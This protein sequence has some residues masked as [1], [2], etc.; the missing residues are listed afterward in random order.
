MLKTLIKKQLLENVA[1]IIRNPKNGKKRGKGA[2]IGFAI[3]YIYL[4]A[5]FG[6]LTF[7]IGD[8]LWE[9]YSALNLEWLYFSVF[10]I[11]ATT[12]GVFMGIFTVYTNLYQAKDNELLLSLP[13]PPS[14]MLIAKMF[15]CYLMTFIFEA[16]VL[17]PCYI[18]YFINS[19]FSVQNFIISVANIL[20]MP[21]FAVAIGCILGWVVALISSKIKK[22]IRTIV[23]VIVSIVFFGAY[24]YIISDA[25]AFMKNFIAHTEK[26]ADVAKS[27]F[28]LFYLFGKGCLGDLKALMIFILI[29]AALIFA[30]IFVLS[31]TFIKIV[32]KEKGSSVKKFKKQSLSSASTGKAL[33]KRE[34]ARYTSSAVYILNCTM[35]VILTV[36]AI[37][38]TILK[39]DILL[40][41]PAEY[42]GIIACGVIAMLA[43]M[44]DITAPSVSLE[45]RTLWIV[46][47]LPV[48]P[49]EILKAKLRM[50]VILSAVP[51][52]IFVGV[53]EVIFDMTLIARIMLPVYA[54][55]FSLCEAAF[56]LMLNIKMP[57]LTWKN[58]TV[59]VK[60]SMNVLAALL[61][62]MGIIILLAVPYFI[63]NDILKADLYIVL[64]AA[65]VLAVTIALLVWIKKKGTEIFSKL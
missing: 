30:V 3:L 41:I 15:N 49:W 61:G 60:Q 36:L 65:V 14:K 5:L 18:V 56:G 21:L 28:Y 31:K 12:M 45:G 2:L 10:G 42:A 35:G 13:I 46:Q 24:Y 7:L 63:W 22:N 34:F 17:I 37:F 50:H 23:I 53:V 62:S 4:F 55:L 25:S 19:P 33:L 43:S 57:N 16:I 38:F 1:F 51:L 32:I 11:L 48:R 39:K 20:I 8:T 47:S 54:V 58:E 44:N 9:P 64:S 59:A 26:V 6:G 52:L 40:M 27:S 29:A